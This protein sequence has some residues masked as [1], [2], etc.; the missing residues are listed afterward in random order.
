MFWPLSTYLDDGV[1]QGSHL[2]MLALVSLHIDNQLQYLYNI[3]SERRQG[4]MEETAAT[5][6]LRLQC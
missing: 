6:S 3:I 2:L 4:Q 1:M 5:V